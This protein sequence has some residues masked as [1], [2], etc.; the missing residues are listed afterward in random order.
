MRWADLGIRIGE[1]ESGRLCRISDV[2]GVTVGHCTVSDARHQTGVTVLFPC[3]D[4]PF[5]SPLPCA[6]HVLNGFGKS[7]GLMQIGELGE[8]ESPIALTN[9]LN[10]GAVHDALVSWTIRRQHEKGQKV[11]T[12]NPVVCECN[13]ASLNDIEQRV[14]GEKEVFRAAKAKHES[15]SEKVKMLAADVKAARADFD[16]KENIY[17][18]IRSKRNLS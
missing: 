2:P 18:A 17:N 14:I 11:R 5:E 16:T 7:L 12:L 1:M 8:L 9:T 6:C 10:V 3:A 13:D 15:A 4:D